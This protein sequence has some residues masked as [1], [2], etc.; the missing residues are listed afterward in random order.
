MMEK[1]SQMK[2][3]LG[4][5]LLWLIH[6]MITDD[7]PWSSPTIFQ[8]ENHRLVERLRWLK[9]TL[10]LSP[11]FRSIF[12]RRMSISWWAL[13]SS[14]WVFSWAIWYLPAAPWVAWN[15]EKKRKTVSFKVSPAPSQV[16]LWACP[17]RQ[18]TCPSP[19]SCATR[20]AGSCQTPPERKALLRASWIWSYHWTLPEYSHFPIACSQAWREVCRS[21]LAISQPRERKI[22][23]LC[24]FDH[25]DR[26]LLMLLMIWIDEGVHCPSLEPER[27]LRYLAV[28]HQGSFPRARREY[29]MKKGALE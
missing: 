21:R 16:L 27:I 2:V 1:E 22:Y 14:S 5:G 25:W 8:I 28:S 10:R 12:S 26:G 11:V 7:H 24:Q 9:L 23:N 19:R 3:G 6:H 13:S 29:E 4:K 18:R 20:P 15:E 17:S